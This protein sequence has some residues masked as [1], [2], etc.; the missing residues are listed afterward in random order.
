M[1]RPWQAI[2]D[3]RAALRDIRWPRDGSRYSFGPL[4][5]DETFYVISRGERGAGFLSNFH[6]VM[7]HIRIALQCGMTPVI[8]MMNYR[9]SCSEGVP[10]NGTRNAW[11]YF[12]E[13]PFGAR[14]KD[15]YRSKSV[16]MASP[17][18]PADVLDVMT[19]DHVN[20]AERIAEASELISRHMAFN[21]PTS[22]FIEDAWSEVRRPGEKILAV[23]S[24][25]ADCRSGR[26]S[27]RPIQPEPEDLLAMAAD[28]K[29]ELGA[30]WIF[31]KAEEE[32]VV[33][34]FVD[35]F[36]DEVMPAKRVFRQEHDPRTPRYSSSLECL[37]DVV[38]ASRC[39]FLLSGLNCG[40]VAAVELNGGRYEAKRIPDLGRYK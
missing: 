36:G 18:Y 26:P 30:R 27:G 3:A 5:P 10:V 37:R 40:S 23:M 31:L 14:L 6:H 8:D 38:I 35:K 20:D 34:L 13:Q 28:M 17:G 2:A 1:I 15:V 7:L 4:A 29:S 22:R 24:R 39:D 12:F 25:G 9:T 32:Y 21:V 11:E 33:R 19:W 16:F